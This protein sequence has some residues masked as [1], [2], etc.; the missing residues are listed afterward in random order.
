[1]VDIPP[2]LSATV[3]TDFLSPRLCSA[4]YWRFDTPEIGDIDFT[5]VNQDGALQ[6]RTYTYLTSEIGDSI[7]KL[8]TRIKV[9]RMVVTSSFE[10][11]F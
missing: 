3:S 6:A 7:E 8:S 5:D 10:A 2:D 9:R 1:M 4:L 11:N